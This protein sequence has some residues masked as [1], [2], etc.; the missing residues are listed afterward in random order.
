MKF[1][2]AGFGSIGRRHFRNL[3]ALGEKDILFFRSGKSQLDDKELSG[4]VVEC[5]LKAAL[6]HKPDAVIV[7]NPSALHLDVAIPAAQA[8]CHILFEKPISN[9]LDRIDELAAAAEKSGSR[10]L[11]SFQYRFHPSLQ[12][13]AKILHS[14]E[15][16]K[17]LSAHAHWGEYL[18]DWHPNEDYRSGYSARA[19]LG[20]GVVLTLSHPFDYLRWLLGEVQEVWG[21]VKR[22]GELEIDVED[23]AEV[24]L[25]FDSGALASVH[26]DYLQ[27]PA[28]HWLEIVCSGGVLHWDA[29]SGQLGVQRV[30]DGSEQQFLPP[31][32]FERNDLF[33]AQMRH[34]IEIAKGEAQSQCTLEDG[35]HALEIALT[36]HQSAKE[37]KRIKLA[38]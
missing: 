22:S 23:E 29:G 7:A 18:P 33:L 34:F 20:G 15:L 14:G 26:L 19:D 4:H 2:I 30:T 27:R 37:G 16:G 11:V 32:G 5:D 17:L 28:A 6:A 13:A 31:A 36:A 8:G 10:V 35:R 21:S 1:L 9:S 24:G 3:K 12:K 38:G 25:E